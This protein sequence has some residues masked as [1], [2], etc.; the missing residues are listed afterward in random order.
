M[1]NED[2]NSSPEAAIAEA[3]IKVMNAIQ[4]L[5]PEERARVLHSVAALYGLSLP[6]SPSIAQSAHSSNSVVSSGGLVA[7]AAPATNSAK[8]LSI[9]EFL[10]QRQAV[11]NPQRIACFAYYREKVEGFENFSRGDLVDYFPQAKLPAPG[12]NY[13]RDYGNAV[14]EGW[15]HDEGAKSYLTQK[16]EGVVESG[17][18][19]KAKP[20]GTTAGKKRRNSKVGKTE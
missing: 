5:I 6:S 10:Q 20:R 19:G 7:A 1:R 18:D 2:I 15:I 16:G 4:T 12:K 3:A 14:K 8:R 9:V 17:F 11:T 13:G